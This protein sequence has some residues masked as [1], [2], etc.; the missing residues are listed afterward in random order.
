MGKKKNTKPVSGYKVSRK[1]V[2]KEV[3]KAQAELITKIDNL[4]GHKSFATKILDRSSSI[5]SYLIPIYAVSGE[6]EDF[7]IDYLNDLMTVETN[8]PVENFVGKKMSEVHPANFTN[9]LFEAL[10]SCVENDRDE[11]LQIQQIFGENQFWFSH[12]M[13]RLDDGVIV[14]TKNITKEKEYEIQLDV[15]NMLLSE[16]EYV[17]NSGSYK[18]NLGEEYIQYSDNAFRLFGYEPNKFKPTM[19]KFMSF[20]HPDDISI[21]AADYGNVIKRKERTEATYRII[22]RDKKIKTIRS[23]GEFY[24]KDGSWYMVGVLADI[25]KQMVTEQRL[26]TRNMELKRSNDELE[27]F[28]RI[29]SHDLQEPLRKIQMFVSRLEGDESN[30]L[31]DHSKEYLNK[32]VASTERMRELITNLLSYSKL[33][34][35]NERPE[36]IDLNQVLAEVKE[37]L[38]QRIEDLGALIAAERLPGLIAIKFQMVQLFSNLIGNSLKYSKPDSTPKIDISATILAHKKVDKSLALSRSKYVKLEFKD[39]GIGFDPS[40]EEKIFEIFQRLHSKNEFS[41]TG[42]GLAICRKIVETHNG[43]IYAKG[44]QGEGAIFTIYLPYSA[45]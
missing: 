25:S 20:V 34:V 7:T 8:E 15:Q 30:R 27:S 43:A 5:I 41:G 9:G 38:A 1:V 14:F 21:L 33:D 36:K 26:R 12:K 16:A 22:T 39:N 11:E 40:H 35:V 3:L 23:V 42:L 45:K 28:N 18:W 32:I 24:K 6:I 4:D 37:D 13:V 19:E 10:V 44:V 31:G 17:G 2:K 29:A